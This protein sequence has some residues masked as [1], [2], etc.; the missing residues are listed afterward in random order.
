MHESR[1]FLR[2][3]GVHE[4]IMFTGRGWGGF[5]LWGIFLVNLLCEF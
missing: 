2:E 4:I 1:F 5:I 3:G